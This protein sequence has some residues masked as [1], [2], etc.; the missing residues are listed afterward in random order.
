MNAGHGV[1]DGLAAVLAEEAG[2]GLIAPL[3]GG[4]GVLYRRTAHVCRICL[5]P[6]LEGENGYICAVCDASGSTP[7]AICGCGIKVQGPGSRRHL[8]ACV[9]N[10]SRGPASPSAIVITFGPGAA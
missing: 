6:V 1:S 3:D 9:P 2:A 4:G 5:G 8:F 10:P 7:E